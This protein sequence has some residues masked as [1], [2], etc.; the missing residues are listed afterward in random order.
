MRFTLVTAFQRVHSLVG[1]LRDRLDA[2]LEGLAEVFGGGERAREEL[3]IRIPVEKNR[4]GPP[5]R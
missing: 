5:R 3:L 2:L 1:D 4:K